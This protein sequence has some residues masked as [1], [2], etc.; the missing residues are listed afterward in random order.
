M[1]MPHGGNVLGRRLH[2]QWQ[3]MRIQDVDYT[4]RGGCRG[5]FSLR[6]VKVATG[7]YHG[8]HEISWH[9]SPQEQ[10]E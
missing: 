10:A 1:G 7:G 2:N 4:V 3:R 6:L 9:Q 8:C 5:Q